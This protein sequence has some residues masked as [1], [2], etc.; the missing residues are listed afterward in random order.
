LDAAESSKVLAEYLR[1]ILQEV[2][3][4]I[5]DGSMVI[6]DRVDFC[7][8]ILRYIAE[9]IEKGEFGFKNDSTTIKR[10]K[11][12][13]IQQDAQMLLSLIDRKNPRYSPM[14]HGEEVVRPE[15]SLGENSLFTG[16]PHEPSMVSELKKEILTSDRID[17]LVSFIKW[18]G[19]RLIIPELKSFTTNGGK[20]RVITTSYLGATDYKAVEQLSRLPNTEIHISYD[21]ERTR[22]HAKTYV[23]W[24]DTGFSTVYIGSSNVSESAMTSGLEWN[25]KLSQYDSQDILEKIRATFEGYWNNPEFVPFASVI[26]KERLQR[27]LK[28]ERRPNGEEARS[29]AFHFDIKPYY[30]QQEILDK[31]QAEREIHGSYKNLVVAATGTGKTVIAAFDYRDFSRKNP[32][33]PNRLLFV[34]HRKEI[35]KQ[36]LDCFR[37]ILKELNFGSIMVGGERPETIDHLFVSIQSFNSQ[38]LIERTTPDFYDYIVVDEAVILGLK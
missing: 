30:F 36:S 24:R 22:L 15:T 8:S 10:V 29:F 6:K 11:G 37:G 18:S 28:S 5:E 35:L 27:A 31:L 23:F 16:A 34:A 2:F 33:R 1:R 19:L 12:F 13:F 9:C 7:N 14:I 21:T 25:I 32:G 20:L 3:N 38:E 4:Y 26:D 17:F